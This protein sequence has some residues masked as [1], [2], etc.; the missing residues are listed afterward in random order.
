MKNLNKYILIT[1][2]EG[3]IGLSVTKLLSNKNFN[4]I[5]IDKKKLYKKNYYKI[6]LSNSKNLGKALKK[7]KKKHKKIDVLINLAAVQVFSDFEK[8]SEKDIDEMINV[9]LKSNILL[10]K[11]IFKEYFKAQKSGKIINIASI[12]GLKSPNFKNYERRDRKSSETYGATK[13]AIIQLTKYFANYMSEY[14]VSVNCISPG[15]VENQKTQTKKFIKRYSKN[16]PVG[17]M[18]KAEEISQLIYFLL[19]DKSGYING[20]NIIIDGGITA[21]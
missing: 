2:S 9:N 4:L 14:N 19:S 3:Q 17:R 5:L 15:G 8:R 1:G 21:K 13:A 18:A 10:S 12:F 6:D 16:V 7:I 11:F 20:Q